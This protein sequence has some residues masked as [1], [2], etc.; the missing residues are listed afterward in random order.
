MKET[1]Y[2]YVPDAARQS[3]LPEEEAG[4]ALRVL[5]LKAGDEMFLMDGVGTFFRAEVTVAAGKH[6]MYEIKD[7]FPH[8]ARPYPSGQ[9]TDEN[10]GTHG[11]DG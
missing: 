8:V 9:C 11:V 10:D 2:F 6:C 3:E 7:R 5:R 4:H 1:R